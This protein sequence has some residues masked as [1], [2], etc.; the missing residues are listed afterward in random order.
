M[1]DLTP[2][3]T[4][5]KHSCEV[6]LFTKKV[7]SEVRV[8]AKKAADEA[9]ADEAAD[10]AAAAAAAAGGNSSG[11]AAP[12]LEK[13]GSSSRSSKEW[14]DK[15]VLEKVGSAAKSAAKTVAS[16][17]LLMASAGGARGKVRLSFSWEGQQ[18][19]TVKWL[20]SVGASAKE[21]VAPAL[22]SFAQSVAMLRS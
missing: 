22:F 10:E 4:A 8:E 15:N 17:P 2:L 12:P 3:A 18:S 11:A 14:G 20:L 9:A 16:R 7:F 1:V 13:R 21:V 5:R 6:E 19:E